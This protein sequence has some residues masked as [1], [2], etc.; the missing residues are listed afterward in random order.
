GVLK[1]TVGG[2]VTVGINIIVVFSDFVK[3]SVIFIILIRFCPKTAVLYIY[4]F[5]VVSK[6]GADIKTKGLRLTVS[7]FAYKFV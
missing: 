2:S 3:G 5:F 6:N 1:R 4:I 7:L